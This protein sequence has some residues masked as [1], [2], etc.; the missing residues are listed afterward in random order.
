[1]G[2]PPA[3]AAAIESA[4]SLGGQIMPPV[5][6][7]AA[8]LMAEFLGKSYFD[9]VARGWIPAIVYYATVSV[10]VY[11]LA[12]KYHIG[13][14]NFTATRLGYAHLTNIAVFVVAVLGL[15]A[16]M[17]IWHLAPMFAALYMFI[18]AAV[19]L[20]GLHYAPLLKSF[21]RSWKEMAAPISRFMFIYSDMIADLAL[22]L[23]T[24]S[25]MTGALVITGVPTKIGALMIDAAGV[26]LGL[27][28]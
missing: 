22:L 28:V 15:I 18:I 14:G 13:R 6:G 7:V 16:L 26:N 4:S 3:T 1:A 17:A 10:S 25:I 24:L 21:P 23:A 5:M 19:L 9:V 12:L 8:F 2:M 20:V 27:M 11:L